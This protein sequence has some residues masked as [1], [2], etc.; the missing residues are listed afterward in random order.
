PD[1]SGA[2]ATAELAIRDH[3][4]RIAMVVTGNT[5][6]T[7]SVQH[8]LPADETGF[9]VVRNETG[10]VLGVSDPIEGEPP[11]ESEWH[12]VSLSRTDAAQNATI[13][14]Y[15]DANGDGAFDAATDEPF[16]VAGRNVTKTVRLS[17]AGPVTTTETAT[18]TPTPT[19]STDSGAG[20]TTAATETTANASD[21]TT[22][23]ETS[24]DADGTTSFVPG[25]GVG[26]TAVALVAAALLATRR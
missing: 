9:L 6:G 14:F 3:V 2:T 23:S 7:V 26:A 24:A 19:A 16:V 21:E 15:D 8:Y 17:A 11:Y 12:R 4:P 10:A 25:F 5:P 22:P 20:A 1:K 13:T 18:A